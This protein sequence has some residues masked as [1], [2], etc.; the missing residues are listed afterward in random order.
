MDRIGGWLLGL[1]LPCCSAPGADLLSSDAVAAILVVESDQGTSVEAAALP[2]RRALDSAADRRVTALLYRD[3]LESLGL[4]AGALAINP[5]GAP[6]PFT[7]LVFSLEV[8]GAG[9]WRQ[10]PE[11]P[12]PVAAIH[13]GPSSECPRPD[14][15]RVPLSLPED[16]SASV[17]LPDDS[18]LVATSGAHFFRVRGSAAEVVD[19]DAAVCPTNSAE[20]VIAGALR[21][22][23]TLLLVTRHGGVMHLGA[24]L[25]PIEVRRPCLSIHEPLFC[26]SASPRG[27]LE[28]FAVSHSGDLLRWTETA[29]AWTP[30]QLASRGA[31]P[32][33]GCTSAGGAVAWIAPGEALATFREPR[34]WWARGDT[35]QSIPLS[36]RA[37]CT[38]SIAAG[39]DGAWILLGEYLEVLGAEPTVALYHRAP[40]GEV[41]AVLAA[42]P[43]AARVIH[44]FGDSVILADNSGRVA[45]LSKEGTGPLCVHAGLRDNDID[46]LVTVGERVLGTGR[47]DDVSGLADATWLG[48]R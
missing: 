48:F 21:D 47:T 19:L 24:D 12:G 7:D 29:T 39:P 22:D 11:I 32:L 33:D 46:Q 30:Y 5:A 8:T 14:T 37:N 28:A 43:F 38:G 17:R 44:P 45:L 31:Q 40:A 6:L 20:Y 27:P 3:S 1:V 13:A 10:L 9:E 23:G 36:S 25:T 34:L 26:A 15:E 35:V 42:I 4:V 18:V 2:I 16:A 41:R